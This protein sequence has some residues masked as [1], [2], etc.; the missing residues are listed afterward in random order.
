M[1]DIWQGILPWID[2]SG[3]AFC[4]ELGQGSQG[5]FEEWEPNLKAATLSFAV[6]LAL[7]STLAVSQTFHA[8]RIA[9]SCPR[10]RRVSSVRV[11]QGRFL[12]DGTGVVVA[13]CSHRLF[14]SCL[15]VVDRLLPWTSCAA[16]KGWSRHHARAVRCLAL[17]RWQQGGLHC[18]WF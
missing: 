18:G 13:V 12:L 7:H 10:H 8:M 4:R 5:G 1:V 3:T 9:S 6:D 16:P 11:W 15:L 17:P 2:A 14:H